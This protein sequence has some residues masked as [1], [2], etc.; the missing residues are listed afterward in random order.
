MSPNDNP[1][2]IKSF[3]A[4]GVLLWSMNSRLAELEKTTAQAATHADVSG[5]RQDVAGLMRRQETIE[6]DLASAKEEWT[7]SK[8]STLFG[9]MVKVVAGLAVIFS[10]LGLLYQVTE[11]LFE[12]KRAAL[13]A[14]ANTAKP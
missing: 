6:R 5:L 1:P 3:E 2:E 9:N 11:T 14:Q 10:F 12:V 8:P 4:L 13:A 7:R